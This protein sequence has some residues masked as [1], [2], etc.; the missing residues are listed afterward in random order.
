MDTSSSISK[1]DINKSDVF[2]FSRFQFWI[3]QMFAD[4]FNK[5]ICKVCL[6]TDKIFRKAFQKTYNRDYP[7]KVI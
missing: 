7:R 4:T 5:E 1:Y 3:F 2:F 6:E